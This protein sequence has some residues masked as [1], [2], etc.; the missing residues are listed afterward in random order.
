MHQNTRALQ[1][2]IPWSNDELSAITLDLLRRNEYREDAY[3]RPLSFKSA[4]IIGV[5]L[6]DVPD[7]FAI[8]TAPMGL[9]VGDS[10]IRAMVSSWR[11]IDDSMA[12]VRTKCTGLYI[13]SAL[14]K[15]EALQGGFDEAIM[16]SNDGHVCE[17]SAENI[18]IVRRGELITPPP[19]DNILEGITRS[20]IMHLVR[21]EMGIEVVER[22]VDRS[23]LYVADEV[24]LAGTGAQIAP[25]IEIDRR[26]VGDG[27]PGPLTLRVQETVP[28]GRHRSRSE[29][30]RLAD[31]RLLN[32]GARSLDARLPGPARGGRQRGCARGAR[33]IE[34]QRVVVERETVS[35]PDRVDEL[36]HRGVVDLGCRTAMPA[37][38]VMVVVVG[39]RRVDVDVPLGLEPLCHPRL[40]E[41]VE[42]PEDGRPAEERM[43][44]AQRV[45]RAPAR[46][47]CDGLGR[48]RLRRSC[49]AASGGGPAPRA[50]RRRSWASFSPPGAARDRD[51]AA[52]LPSASSRR[53]PIPG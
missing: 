33:S 42:G 8:V 38:E 22:S 16:L 3:I 30:R 13:N 17:G 7:S 1:M 36:V 18:F 49:V 27:E 11:R 5:K 29:V 19:S 15:S 46:S 31:A 20:S 21:E 2:N 14:A 47:R 45:R 32:R 10:G 6:H 53:T 41:E 28:Q 9:Y 40:D 51:G 50:G 52:R 44:G 37:D 35:A 48:A 4:E 39:A 43:L 24:F 34:V 12:P 23:E 25:V 26:R